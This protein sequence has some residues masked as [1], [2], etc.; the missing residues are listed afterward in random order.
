MKKKKS[1][2]KLMLCK[3]VTLKFVS[4][5]FVAINEVGTY[6]KKRE[7]ITEY[8]SPIPVCRL[9]ANHVAH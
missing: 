5:G 3:G 1:K 7:N 8:S 4:Q 6:V 9:D 2:K